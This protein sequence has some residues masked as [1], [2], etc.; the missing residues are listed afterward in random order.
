[1]LY[2]AGHARPPWPIG[3]WA[4]WAEW[5]EVGGGGQ[6]QRKVAVG[7]NQGILHGRGSF[8]SIAC[9]ITCRVGVQSNAGREPSRVPADLDGG[10]TESSV[11][12]P[13]LGV[14]RERRVWW[15]T[16]TFERSGVDRVGKKGTVTSKEMHV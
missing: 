1:M 2:T 10:T 11:V 12:R 7:A 5:A 6:R 3:G 8:Y 15:G 16:G 14:H 4:E 13:K 9:P